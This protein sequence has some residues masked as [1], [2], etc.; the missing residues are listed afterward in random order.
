[1]GNKLVGNNNAQIFEQELLNNVIQF[2]DCDEQLKTIYRLSLVNKRISIHI[3]ESEELW[4]FLSNLICKCKFCVLDNGKLLSNLECISCHKNDSHIKANFWKNTCQSFLAHKRLRR[5]WNARFSSRIMVSQ[6]RSNIMEDKLTISIQQ[7]NIIHNEE[8]GSVTR[9]D[10]GIIVDHNKEINEMI[11]SFL[12]SEGELFGIKST[13]IN[14]NTCSKSYKHSHLPTSLFINSMDLAEIT[15]PKVCSINEILPIKKQSRWTRFY[16]QSDKDKV[17]YEITKCIRDL[18]LSVGGSDED[19]HHMQWFHGQIQM[20]LLNES[21]FKKP[22]RGLLIVVNRSDIDPSIA[23][24]S[25][26]SLNI[27]LH[28]R[29][30]NYLSDL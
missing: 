12:R 27:R 11:L 7:T 26:L 16:C 24:V 3:R 22:Q 8:L 13:N 4:L 29:I 17:N 18:I 20:R 10:S 2:F 19:H 30:L 25:G 1:M 14:E 23:R 15:N 6:S 5:Q 21:E 9:E 28:K